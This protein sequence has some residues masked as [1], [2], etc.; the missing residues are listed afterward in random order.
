L[1]ER[2][3]DHRRILVQQ[4]RRP[5][6]LS[7]DSRNQR[8]GK[9]DGATQSSSP[10][11]GKNSPGHPPPLF[12]AAQGYPLNQSARR[13]VAAVWY[14]SLAHSP[15]AHVRRLGRPGKTLN[16]LCIYKRGAYSVEGVHAQWKLESDLRE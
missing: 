16:Q 6:G 11:S 10:L 5:S 13:K 15:S 7:V 3:E 14:P 8:V 12:D 4:I 9:V 1:Q 2:Q